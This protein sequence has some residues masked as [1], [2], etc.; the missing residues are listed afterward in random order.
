MTYDT[1]RNRL[2]VSWTNRHFIEY[3]GADDPTS[4]VHKAQAGPNGPENNENLCYAFSEDLGETWKFPRSTNIVNL[5]EAGIIGTSLDAVAV[6]IPRDSGIMNQESQCIDTSGGFHVLNRD[7]VDGEENWKHYHLTENKSWAVTA[8]PFRQPT[9]MSA[10]GKLIHCP[11]S[12]ALY[13]VLPASNDN[14]NLSVIRARRKD[15]GSF[16]EHEIIW[17]GKGCDGEVLVD[18]QA[19]LELG[20]LCIFTTQKLLAE[21]RVVVLEFSLKDLNESRG[22]IEM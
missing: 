16:G 14:E 6:S 17:I 10:R 1:T 12:D 9:A 8:I 13:F 15:D 4:T 2:H 20:I 3:E 21:R 22:Y 5:A 11:E 19:V 18:E 7:N